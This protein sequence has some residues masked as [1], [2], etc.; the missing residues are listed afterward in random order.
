MNKFYILFVFS[1]IFSAYSFGQKSNL[2]E[3][4]GPNYYAGLA[5]QMTPLLLKSA[6]I[7][8]DEAAIGKGALVYVDYALASD[9]VIEGLNALGYTTTLGTS[10]PDF[11]T[12][13]ES[14]NFVLAVAFAQNQPA[15]SYG[16]SIS[17][18]QAFI[19]AGGNMVFA[20]WTS[21]DAAIVN[22]FGAS[23]SGHNNQSTVTI[24]DPN[25]AA[26]ITNPFTLL[27]PGWNTFST[28]LT[29]LPESEV[30]ATFENGD[31]AIVRANGGKTILLGYLSDT[32]NSEERQ[33][34]FEN[35]VSILDKSGA[36]L[37]VNAGL[38]Q[39][40]DEGVVVTLDASYSYD[41]FRRPLTYVWKAPEGITL[42][43]TTS[44]KPT[45]VAPQVDKETK[46]IFLLYVNNG[47]T[48]SVYDQVVVTVR[49][50][51]HA[52]IANAGS[53]QI[54]N[55]GAA[56]V[57]NGSFSSDP[58][59]DN[60]TYSWLAPENVVLTGATTATPSFTTTE[61]SADKTLT[62]TL[63]VSDGTLT[64]T[65]QVDVIV[66]QINKAPVANAGVDQSVNEG[67]TVTLNGTASADPDNDVLTYSW[68]AP[69]GITLSGTT[70]A[71][72]TFV[73]PEVKADTDYSFALTVSDG[74]LTSTSQVKVT[75]KQ[76][77]KAPVANAGSA[78]TVKE[79][80]VV[81]L[82]GTASADSDGDVLTYKWTAPDGIT[83]SATT[84]ASPVFTAPATTTTV[85][86]TF[87]LVVNDGNLDSQQATVTI[88]VAP[89]FTSNRSISESSM[90]VYPNP[91]TEQV[92]IDLG[93][94]LDSSTQAAVYSVNG[95]LV[96]Q[97]E[98][99]NS[100]TTIDLSGLSSGAYVV[101]V[102]SKGEVQTSKIIKR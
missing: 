87:G 61:V 84:T 41:S 38:N 47:V 20:T 1:F 2:I 46:Y 22:L 69:N 50:V 65:A 58:D 29:A 85:T 94:N 45:F 89:I 32:P 91:F 25:L 43:S 18:A 90:K 70:T 24:T 12:K 97:K 60:I 17:I 44:M 53:S 3:G 52:P 76:V 49:N 81:T 64:A 6:T 15:L 7:I 67:V 66:K 42:S 68:V 9:N 73:A 34:I 62:F 19:N 98:L 99:T 4:S 59:G 56:V 26:G 8:S 33:S 30:L 75:V 63:T 92:T 82:D 14:G 37:V 86:F 13:L 23:L 21:S 74:T 71:S 11:N 39:V 88:T 31:A 16:F 27:N 80:S 102:L 57:L 79:K 83:L 40:V 72:P 35:V 51:N 48:N 77:N 95:G 10:W 100:K 96:L 5:D 36:S 78:K 55:E 54:V 101:K 93:E 28:G